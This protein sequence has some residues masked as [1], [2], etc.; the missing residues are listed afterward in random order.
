MA[1]KYPRFLFSNPQNTKSKGP[2]VFHTIFPKMLVRLGYVNTY[3]T[4]LVG[5]YDPV[6]VY[7]TCTEEELKQ[8]FADIDTWIHHQIKSG[9]IVF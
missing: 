8:V 5:T 3:G 9:E 4:T 6:E 2:F 1:R 7:D